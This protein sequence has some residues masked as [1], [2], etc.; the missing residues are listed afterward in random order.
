MDEGIISV[1]TLLK[2]FHAG[3]SKDDDNNRF[4]NLE[5]EGSYEKVGCLTQRFRIL[6]FTLNKYVLQSLFF[7]I[8]FFKT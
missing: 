2:V 3:G 5:K 1:A 6:C 8:F 4:S 7:P